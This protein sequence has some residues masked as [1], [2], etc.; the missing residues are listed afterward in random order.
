VATTLSKMK[1][2]FCVSTVSIVSGRVPGSTGVV[3]GCIYY[4]GR[5]LAQ[6][7]IVIVGADDA[8]GADGIFGPRMDPDHPG[9][10]STFTTE[11]DV[12]RPSTRRNAC[13]R[14][15]SPGSVAVLGHDF[16]RLDIDNAL[17]CSLGFPLAAPE[18]LRR[19]SARGD[20]P[21]SELW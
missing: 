16:S 10:G 4:L 12:R 17:D 3:A 5:R 13:A 21:L 11:G 15:K 18:S 6:P 8:D 20:K 7:K 19:P 1:G 14:R 9:S 2:G